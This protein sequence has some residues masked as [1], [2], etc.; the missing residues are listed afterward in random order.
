V[1]HKR[2]FVLHSSADNTRKVTLAR[3][4]YEER[5]HIGVVESRCATGAGVVR[6]TKGKGKRFPILRKAAIVL[7][8]VKGKPLRGGFAT[9]D[10][11]C[12]RRPPEPGRD[13]RTVIVLI[14]Q[15]NM[16]C[17]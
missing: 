17:T 15:K 5:L 16:G 6:G 4:L 9:L 3:K 2:W 11:R 10:L 1:V 13:R 14:E 12:G 7:T 8:P